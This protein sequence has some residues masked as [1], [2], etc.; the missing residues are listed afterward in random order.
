MR[1]SVS[2][3]L[4]TNCLPDDPCCPFTVAGSREVVRIGQSASGVVYGRVLALAVVK[5]V[6]TTRWCNAYFCLVV[7]M[8]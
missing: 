3:S 7:T 2:L 8:N 5:S 4:F 6:S 1:I